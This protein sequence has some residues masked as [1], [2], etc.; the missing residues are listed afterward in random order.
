MSSERSFDANHGN[1]STGA[2]RQNG[3]DTTGRFTRPQSVAFLI[4]HTGVNDPDGA[5]RVAE[6]LG[7]LPVALEQAATTI[8]LVG[9]PRLDDYLANLR[10]FGLDESANGPSSGGYGQPISRPADGPSKGD[11]GAQLGD[12]YEAT[13]GNRRTNGA[14]PALAPT[15]LLMA[16][17]AVQDHLAEK[18]IASGDETAAHAS[19]AFLQLAALALLAPSG[20]P[21]HW[22][23]QT[24]ASEQIARETLEELVSL[25]VC[26]P[27]ADGR[28]ISI[29]ELQGRAFRE[30]LATDPSLFDAVKRAVVRMLEITDMKEAAADE[31]QRANVL[32]MVI[33]L[34]AVAERDEGGALHSPRESCID[35]PSAFGLVNNTIYCLNMIDSPQIAITFEDTVRKLVSSYGA[36]HPDTFAIR[37]N[38]ALA[39]RETGE[40]M[41]AI[42]AY[43]SLFAE[44]LRA[45]GPDHPDTLDTLANLAEAHMET[46]DFEGAVGI[47]EALAADQTRV[48]GPDDAGTLGTRGNLAESYLQTGRTQQAIDLLKGFVRDVDRALGPDHPYTLTTRNRLARAYMDAG[49]FKKA[50]KEL[51]ALLPD[52]IRVLGPDHPDT[53]AVRSNL[54]Y[55]CNAVGD[56]GQAIDI[57]G[58][59]IAD[60]VRALGPDH[61]LTLTARSNLARA[62]TVSGNPQKAIEILEAVLDSQFRS[63][64]VDHPDALDTRGDLA[65]AYSVLG[66]YQKAIAM[67]QS[68]LDDQTRILGPDHPD[69]LL[70]R[71]SLAEALSE[72]QE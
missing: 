26:T 31:A 13:S 23:Y 69:T 33:Q 44:R 49:K 70:T 20:V 66:D 36:D 27:S 14:Q 56:Y 59:L 62:H 57:L 58:E 35:L 12:E 18:D 42:D 71:E 22:L 61:Y 50:R 64:G 21:R 40:T 6:A 24:G 11:C 53:L 60:E 29:H 17:Q 45:L 37:T 7:D 9:Y 55:I 30:D 19:A 72:A 25:S 5:A 34:N 65:C 68:L 67:F 10:E 41:K 32:D 39:H 3:P 16:R 63:L 48:L 15:A 1:E 4:E 2:S 46:G 38:L 43:E 28:Y 52:R 47:L 54:A 51:N 8:R